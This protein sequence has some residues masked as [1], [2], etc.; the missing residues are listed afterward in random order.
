MQKRRDSK[1]R[2]LR[3]NERQR[4]DG[5]YEYRYVGPDGRKKSVYSWRLVETDVTPAG[6]HDR[7][8]L[9]SQ[10]AELQLATL[11]GTWISGGDMTVVQLC[12]K[13]ILTKTGVKATTKV[14]YQTVM[15]ILKKESFG[16]MKINKIH[17]SDAKLF[18]IKLQKE[19]GR[20]YSS[21]HSIRGV[22]RPAFQ[23]ACD[24]EI[25]RKNP[26]DWQLASVLVDDSHMREAVS[27]NDERRFLDFLRDDPH[28]NMYYDGIYL[29]FKTG[30]RISELCGLSVTD[31]NFKKR[32][33]FVQRQLQRSRDGTLYIET[34]KTDSGSRVIPIGD[35]ICQCLK[36]IIEAR[37]NPEVEP[38][39]DGQAGFLFL[40]GRARKGLRPMVAMDWE[41]IFKRAT[42]K[43]NSIY[44]M[45][46]P[47][48]TPHVCRH[49]YCSNMAKSGMNPKVL[50]YLMGHSDISVTLNTYTH[51]DVE[52]AKEEVERMNADSYTSPSGK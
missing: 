50:Q 17:V 52:T 2:I 9:R 43:Y 48:I 13:Y 40:N 29:L 7:P 33:L 39:V 20:G 41:H 21:I 51:M 28:F 4:K 45:Q 24:D 26:F 10:E 3:S 16:A 31:L 32:E 18:L 11:E 30:L 49:T 35:D 25:I 1:G 42:D 23:M 8:S 19:D 37:E 47:R 36:R 27:R 5:S 6:K 44:R 12:E 46:L 15:N 22:L 38:I 14:G 34:P